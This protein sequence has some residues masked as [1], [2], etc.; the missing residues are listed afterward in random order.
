MEGREGKGRVA[1]ELGRRHGPWR[2]QSRVNSY[3]LEWQGHLGHAKKD[4]L[5]VDIN[6]E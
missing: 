4:G 6:T 2:A 1:G 5:Y 3:D